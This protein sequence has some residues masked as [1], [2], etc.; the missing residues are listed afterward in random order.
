MSPYVIVINVSCITIMLCQQGNSIKVFTYFVQ[1]CVHNPVNDTAL[2]SS[3]R[4][5]ATA[6]FFW[7]DKTGENILSS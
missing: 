5:D 4:T 7:K 6:K 3:P 1:R 2:E